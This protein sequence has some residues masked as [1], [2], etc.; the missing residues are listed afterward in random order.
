MFIIKYVLV[1][2]SFAIFYSKMS[3]YPTQ[4]TFFICIVIT[5]KRRGLDVFLGGDLST[6]HL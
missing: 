6:Y 4:K 3:Y 2:F 1:L 5:N